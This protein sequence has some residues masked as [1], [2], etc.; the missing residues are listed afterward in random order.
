MLKESSLVSPKLINFLQCQF[1]LV[2]NLTLNPRATSIPLTV[3]AITR[4]TADRLCNNKLY[5]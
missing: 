5:L 2:V 4:S 3:C 1:V